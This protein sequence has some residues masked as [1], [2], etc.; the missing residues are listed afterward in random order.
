[1]TTIA[2]RHATDRRRMPTWALALALLAA[3]AAALGACHATAEP[4]A[5]RPTEPAGE[6]WLAP[7]CTEPAGGGAAGCAWAA[8][9]PCPDDGGTIPAGEA[10]CYWDAATMGDGGGRSYVLWADQLARESAAA[11]PEAG[12]DY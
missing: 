4:P 6:R 7:H 9:P 2:M 12:H 10:G 8:I 11:A 5:E 1:M 3:L